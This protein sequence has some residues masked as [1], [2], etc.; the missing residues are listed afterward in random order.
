MEERIITAAIG[1]AF[2]GVGILCALLIPR[3]NRFRATL[4]KPANP[5]RALSVFTAYGIRNYIGFCIGTVLF[6]LLL[7][8]VGATDRVHGWERQ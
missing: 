7:I 1:A 2:V 5:R 6:G 3:I 8:F 4:R